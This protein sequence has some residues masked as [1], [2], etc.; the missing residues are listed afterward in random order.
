MTTDERVRQHLA[1]AN[2]VP[3]P[4]KLDLRSFDPADL[5]EARRPAMS[6]ERRTLHRAPDPSPRRRPGWAVALAAAVVVAGAAVGGWVLMR[7]DGE[8][9]VAAPVDTVPSTTLPVD[10]VYDIVLTGSNCNPPSQIP[11]GN[12]TFV[13]TN[14]TGVEA[15]HVWLEAPIDGHTY[16]EYTAW[17]ADEGGF[18]GN[19]SHLVSDAVRKNFDPPRL[20]LADNQTRI[21]YVLEPGT[22]AV[23][24]GCPMCSV[25][26]AEVEPDF[27]GPQGLGAV[28][29]HRL[30]VVEEPGVYDIALTDGECVIPSQVPA[31][32][33]TFVLTN[34]TGLEDVRPQVF[35]FTEGGSYE[36]FA[37]WYLSDEHKV[38]Y[39]F[40]RW[41]RDARRNY[42][43]PRLDLADGQVQIDLVLEP[44]T[45]AVHAGCTV[46]RVGDA[47]VEPDVWGAHGDADGGHIGAGWLCGPLEVVEP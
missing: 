3:D 1:D 45:Y 40:P 42:R 4:G 6:T 38:G 41:A 11:A 33:A 10:G 2:P 22:Y 29:V 8:D 32:A 28:W 19:Q 9:P 20:D 16:E 43:A 14:T 31:G 12:A 27:R 35:R 47:D 5:P 26:D 17:L 15:F 23:M 46:C 36:D 13:L 18:G 34:T 44:G 25:G 21:D 30:D 7:G 24:V 39:E 37:E